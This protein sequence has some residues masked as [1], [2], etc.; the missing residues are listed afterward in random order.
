MNMHELDEGRYRLFSFPQQSGQHKFNNLQSVDILKVSTCTL[1]FSFPIALQFI[2]VATIYHVL[3]LG[4][5]TTG[6]VSAV[7]GSTKFDLVPPVATAVDRAENPCPQ[8]NAAGQSIITTWDK[9][10][11]LCE[12]DTNYQSGDI[13]GIVAYTLQDCADACA[14]FA[15]FNGRCDSFTHDADV[16]RSYQINNGANCWLKN[17]GL[18]DGKNIDYN[19]SSAKLIRRA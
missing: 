2:M 13:T 7:L 14:T 17:F 5:M 6:V 1:A 10:Q 16:A 11:Y 19:G 4:S 18:T 15:M 8:K 9:A 3:V 12:D